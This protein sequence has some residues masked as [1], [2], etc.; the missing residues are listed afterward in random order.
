[1]EAAEWHHE[2]TEI[3]RRVARYVNDNLQ[4]VSSQ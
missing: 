3:D 2:A 4:T 1:M